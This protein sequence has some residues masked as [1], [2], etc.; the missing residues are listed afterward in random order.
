MAPFSFCFTKLGGILKSFLS[1]LYLLSVSQILHFC[2]IT[3]LLPL[4]S[5]SSHLS[6]C[7]NLQIGLPLLHLPFSYCHQN[8]LS[9]IKSD[10]VS[11]L[12]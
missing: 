4:L 2:I 10:H 9:E 6:F 5:P 11:L 12:Q 1:Q 3:L 8:D 7:S